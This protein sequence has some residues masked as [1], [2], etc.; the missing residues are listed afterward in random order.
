MD[1]NLP[2]R[3]MR[4]MATKIERVRWAAV[5]RAQSPRGKHDWAAAQRDAGYG[6]APVAPSS[7]EELAPESPD[8]VYTPSAI[9]VHQRH[10]PADF[11]AGRVRAV[12]DQQRH[13]HLRLVTPDAEAQPP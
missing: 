8:H 11:L 5:Y 12:A 2:M 6:G 7:P 9:F 13:M 1:G 10:R 3:L 4:A